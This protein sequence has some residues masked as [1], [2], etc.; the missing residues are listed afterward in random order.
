M[1]RMQNKGNVGGML[2]TVST[3]HVSVRAGGGE[4]G[5]S[6]LAPVGVREAWLLVLEARCVLALFVLAI[7]T[8]EEAKTAAYA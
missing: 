8:P 2:R 7:A 5:C 6:C 4:V 3:R 1:P